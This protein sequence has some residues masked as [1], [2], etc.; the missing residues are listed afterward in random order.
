MLV[1]VLAT[2]GIICMIAGL[3]IVTDGISARRPRN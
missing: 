3:I 2:A 1:P